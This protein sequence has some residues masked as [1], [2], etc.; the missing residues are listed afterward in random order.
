MMYVGIDPGSK[1]SG[2]AAVEQGRVLAV[3]AIAACDEEHECA[4]LAADLPAIVGWRGVV[5]F[6]FAVEGQEYRHAQAKGSPNDQ[7]K[8]AH[9][10]GAAFAALSRLPAAEMGMF[11]VPSKWKGT[12][13]KL[14]HHRRMLTKLGWK[15][16]EA[17]TG[18]NAYCVPT[19]FIDAPS[20]DLAKIT[21]TQWPEVLDAIGIA[22]WL[23]EKH[24][25][26]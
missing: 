12:V 18:K 6:R 22:L 23:E 4:C 24:R 20:Y 10:A 2:F 16:T 21:K 11:V 9:A 25:G 19:E 26:R 17:G 3:A 14:P 7:F 15:W 13:P 8:L 1:C 5:P